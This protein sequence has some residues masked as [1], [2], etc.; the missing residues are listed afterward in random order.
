MLSKV[1][2]MHTKTNTNQ[3]F[4]TMTA[5]P[6][7]IVRNPPST[8][9]KIHGTT[10]DDVNGQLAIA[11]QFNAERG[12][13]IIHLVTTQVTM[14]IKPENIIKAT[15]IETYQAQFQQIRKDPR[16]RREITKYYNM[17]Q[18]KLGFK[19]EYA[20]AAAA[21]LF[22]AIVFILGVSRTLMIVS[23][24]MIVAL[25]I[26][27]DV[28]NG[29]APKLILQTF[30]RRCRETIEQ[31]APF[32][33]GRLTDA[34]ATGIVVVMLLVAGSTLF[35][36][37]RRAAAKAAAASGAFSSPPEDDG[38]PRDLSA[39]NFNYDMPVAPPRPKSPFG[40]G[41]AM[42]AFFIYRTVMHL[43]ND[44]T[45]FSVERAIA[46]AK[47]MDM[48]T[49]GILAFSVYNCVKPFIA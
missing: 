12:R 30:P 13:Y 2:Q 43:G 15:T 29:L 5:D 27:P 45:G 34:M 3:I 35:H 11:V 48:M 10:R 36:S 44:G 17:A 26:G 41:Q 38:T 6:L 42:S 28:A 24:I 1:G 14:A 47:Q 4:P 18:T 33:R 49:M 20:G 7:N 19:P 22:L 40:M 8:V 16:I 9:V 46:T 32:V 21:L 37:P 39:S 23:M 31:S 25:I